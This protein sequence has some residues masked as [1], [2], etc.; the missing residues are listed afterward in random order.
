M[1]NGCSIV[2]EITNGNTNQKC[3]AKKKISSFL[4]VQVLPNEHN[5]NFEKKW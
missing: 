4:N 2:P 3:I 1:R 5:L